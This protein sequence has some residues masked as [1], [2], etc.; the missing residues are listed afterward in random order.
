MQNE[1]LNIPVKDFLQ[2]LKLYAFGFMT[3]VGILLISY[4]CA[5]FFLTGGTEWKKS[6]TLIL[7]IRSLFSEKQVQISSDI[8]KKKRAQNIVIVFDE[9][10][11]NNKFIGINTNYLDELKSA[12]LKFGIPEEKIH[13]LKIDS[14]K[15][16]SENVHA[17]EVAKYLLT[18]SVKSVLIQTGEMQSNRVYTSYKNVLN[19]LG[20][21]VSIFPEKGKFT[22][23]SWFNSEEGIEL[24]TTELVK[25][26]YYTIKGNNHVSGK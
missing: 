24:V 5:P 17:Q 23:T 8:L 1:S 19:P 14:T 21:G 26:I 10:F 13:I 25:Y 22:A 12:F 4:F 20:I 9:S 11:L 16:K 18:L 2:K 7:E 15:L 6:D 3:P